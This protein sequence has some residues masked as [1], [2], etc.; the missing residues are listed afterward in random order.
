MSARH[1]GRSTTLWWIYGGLLFIVCPF[2]H[3]L[4]TGAKETC[5]HC[6]EPIKAA[7]SVCKHCRRDL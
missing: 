3:I 6:A 5:P 2:P 4:L 1:K 7:A